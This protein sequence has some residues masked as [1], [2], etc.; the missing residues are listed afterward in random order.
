M[1]GK[2]PPESP[3]IIPLTDK[4]FEARQK[5]IGILHLL[6]IQ[7][8]LQNELIL[9]STAQVAK[10]RSGDS[11]DNT[12]TKRGKSKILPLFSTEAL[13]SS[14]QIVSYL[15]LLYFKEY[16][17]ELTEFDTTFSTTS[18]TQSSSSPFNIQSDKHLLSS[19]SSARGSIVALEVANKDLLDALSSRHNDLE[20]IQ[21]ECNDWQNKYNAQVETCRQHGPGFFLS[22]Y[23]CIVFSV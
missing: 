22:I 18:F 4:T 20:K 23:L 8:T 5:Y 9:F 15:N 3:D 13:K 10:S 2:S 21:K 1:N 19:L 17:D 7:Q 11:A 16:T 12:P 14:L 6:H